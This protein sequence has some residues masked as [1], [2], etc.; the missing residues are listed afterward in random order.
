MA[1]E[2]PQGGWESQQGSLGCLRGYGI[3]QGVLAPFCSHL[4]PLLGPLNASRESSRAL[5]TI[6]LIPQIVS[7]LFTVSAPRAVP[8]L[9]ACSSTGCVF[10]CRCPFVHIPLLLLLCIWALLHRGTW[11]PAQQGSSGFALPFI[12]R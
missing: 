1:R 2:T 5:F 11:Q 6:P 10:C 8:E 12:A 4:A 3:D 7:L 9:L